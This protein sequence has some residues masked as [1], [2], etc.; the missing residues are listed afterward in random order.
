[1][2]IKPIITVPDEVLKKISDPLEMVGE[3]EKKLKKIKNMF[4][5]KKI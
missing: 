1:M 5:Q 3:S 4:Y 2:S